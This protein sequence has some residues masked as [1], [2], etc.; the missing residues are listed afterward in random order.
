MK[1][2]KTILVVALLLVLTGCLG[3]MTPSEKTEE[4]MNRYIKNDANIMEE[5]DD[6]MEKQDLST[7]QKERY[8]NI[9]KD[10]YSTIKYKIKDEVIDGDDAKV[11]VDIEVKDLYKCSNDAG[12]YLKDHREEFLTDDVY[13]ENKFIDYKLSLMEKNTDTV[14]YTITIELKKTDNI[15]TIL[16]M[17]NKTLEKIHGIYNYD[18]D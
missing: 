3:N 16:E 6:Y 10:E 9:I 7:E 14:K 1:K 8:K 15:W 11:T 2:I 5:L 17:D 13:D 4:L 18:E 12:V